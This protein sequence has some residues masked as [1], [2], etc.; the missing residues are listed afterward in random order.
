M[1]RAKGGADYRKAQICATDKWLVDLWIY[2]RNSFSTI[3][4]FKNAL[5]TVVVNLLVNKDISCLLNV[6]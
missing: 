2:L 1:V 6:C 5:F 4:E 3:N